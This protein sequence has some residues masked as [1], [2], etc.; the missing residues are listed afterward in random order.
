LF[1]RQAKTGTDP[2][3]KKWAADKLP[4]LQEHLKMARELNAKVGG[5]AYK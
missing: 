2:E 4:H 1:Q 5:G 3:L